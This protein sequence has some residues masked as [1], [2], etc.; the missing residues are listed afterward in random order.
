MERHTPD[1]HSANQGPPE[2]Q[3]PR[4]RAP[5]SMSNRQIY[6]AATIATLVMIGIAAL[7][8]WFGRPPGE[9]RP[10]HYVVHA[11]PVSTLAGEP[12]PLNVRVVDTSGRPAAGIKLQFWRDGSLIDS[13]ETDAEGW[14]G[15]NAFFPRPGEQ[16][17]VVLP[18]PTEKRNFLILNEGRTVIR[19]TVS[20]RQ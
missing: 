13:A 14:A 12:T 17:V 11:D 7:S 9:D 5:Q 4:D 19:V 10:V 16:D 20:G 1:D 2:E 3:R 15:V 8:V 6:V 18:D